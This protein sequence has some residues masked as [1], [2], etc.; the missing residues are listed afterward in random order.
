MR[1]ALSII[2]GTASVSCVKTTAFTCDGDSSVCSGAGARCEA[3]GFCSIPSS[4]CASMFEY[5]DTAGSLAGQCVGGD[6]QPD[7]P[8]PDGPEPDGPAGGCQA[9]Y[10]TIANGTAG[11]K[12]LLVATASPWTDQQ[13]L[14][15][16]TSGGYMA[17][18]D[19]L[20][21]LGAIA[22]KGGSTRIWLGVTDSATDGV[23]L[24]TKNLPYTALPLIGNSQA[25]DCATTSNGLVL[26]VRDCAGG[27][28]L[29]LPTV[30]ECED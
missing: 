1:W 10:D 9:G 2:I 19:D 23:F 13:D 7:G 12:Y 18:P 14:V 6:V 25:D 29:D 4:A 15:C 8:Q 21:E 24:D 5:S 26:D 30:C 3:D 16:A 17:I 11:H 27:G 22:I 20:T 28:Q